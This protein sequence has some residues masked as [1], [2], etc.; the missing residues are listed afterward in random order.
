[1]IKD[2]AD[3]VGEGIRNDRAPAPWLA[4]DVGKISTQIARRVGDTGRLNDSSCDRALEG[5][6]R[7]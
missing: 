2:G 3:A 5:G 4:C 6:I 7:P 1:M